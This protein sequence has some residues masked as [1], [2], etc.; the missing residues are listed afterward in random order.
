MKPAPSAP[1][2]LPAKLVQLARA[3]IGT[4]EVNGTNC[5]PRVNEYKAAT[6]LPPDEPWPWCAAF[7]CW[8]VR[9]ALKATATAETGAFRR[10]VTAGAWDFINW[11]LRQDNT[12]L[13]KRD[14]GTDILPGDIVVF[15][16]S[17]IGL[18]VTAPADGTVQ[19]IEGNT[20]GAGS[21]EGGAVLQKRRRLPQIRARIRFTV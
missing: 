11:S 16:F 17:H 18:A 12:T 7:I 4:A 13:T 15:K 14:P 10:P 21:R 3:E 19:T 5:G 6:N 9:E 1:A 2:R 20:D 8:L